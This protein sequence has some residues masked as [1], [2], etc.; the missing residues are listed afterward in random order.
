VRNFWDYR[1]VRAPHTDQAISE[2]LLLGISGGIVMGYFSF[3]YEGYDPMARILT[4]NTFDPWVTMLSRLGVEQEIRHTSKPDKAIHNLTDTLA[5]GTPAIV[6]AD[7]YSLP[8]NTLPYDEGMWAMFPILVYGYDEADNMVWLAD[9]ARVPL[10]VTTADLHTARARVKKDKFRIITLS[11][12]NWDRLATA[13]SAGIWDTLKLFTEKPAKGSKNNFGFNAFQWFAKLLTTPKTRLSW[14][15]EFPAGRKLLAGLM[16]VY[17]DLYQFGK[18]SNAERDT[19]ADFLDEA[20]LILN[21]PTLC[22]AAEQFRTSAAAWQAL[23]PL[24]LPGGAPLLAETRRLMDREHTLF[25]QQG[26]GS[27]SE[28]KQIHG[29]LHSLKQQAETDFPLNEPQVT[30]LLGTIGAQVLK[31][32]DLEQTAVTTLQHAMN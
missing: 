25:L 22:E 2:A 26:N 1:G 31:I 29:R 12:P 20:S 15:K 28:R 24:L 8:Y 17:S 4:R 21:R 23:A 10:T 18:D 6:W 9:R 14:A 16:S 19:Y 30:N 32:H 3:A 11:P 7:M 13:V 5:A 27:L